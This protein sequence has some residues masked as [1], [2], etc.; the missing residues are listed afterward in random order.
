VDLGENSRITVE[1]VVCGRRQ[2]LGRTYVGQI[3]DEMVDL[4]TNQSVNVFVKNVLNGLRVVESPI[5]P[6]VGSCF[7]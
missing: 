3:K 5:P 4:Q 1:V 6:L 7:G 2:I